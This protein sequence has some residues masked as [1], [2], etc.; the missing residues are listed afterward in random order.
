VPERVRRQL[1]RDFIDAPFVE[2]EN[3]RYDG[4]GNA[5]RGGSA[6][7]LVIQHN[8]VGIGHGRNIFCRP[9]IDTHQGTP[10]APPLPDRSFGQNVGDWDAVANNRPD[11]RRAFPTVFIGFLNLV[12]CPMSVHLR[13]SSRGKGRKSMAKSHLALVAPATV[14]GTVEPTYR[15]PKRVRNAEVRARDFRVALGPPT[16]HQRC[17]GIGSVFPDEMSRIDDL[18]LA[19]G[20]PLME[21]LSA[22]QNEEGSELGHG[23]RLPLPPT[24]RVWRTPC[25]RAQFTCFSRLAEDKAGDR[26]GVLL[27]TTIR[28][29]GQYNTTVYELNDRYRGVFG[30]RDIVFMQILLQKS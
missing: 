27:L 16:H 19:L 20:Q 15:P 13:D 10:P 1:G 6:Q 5:L 11:V 30:R 29:H 8:A 28:S 3:S 18:Q 2:Q 26:P 4:L 25:G 21:I 14:I 9:G 17:I 24:D 22:S 23:F 12:G 7:R